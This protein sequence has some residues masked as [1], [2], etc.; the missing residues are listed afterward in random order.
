MKK[1]AVF[2]WFPALLAR[3]TGQPRPAPRIQSDPDGPRTL[4]RFPH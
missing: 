4:L 2:S 3:L 1:S